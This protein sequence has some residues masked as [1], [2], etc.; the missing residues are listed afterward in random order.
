[1]TSWTLFA[2]TRWRTNV[3]RP[4][5]ETGQGIGNWRGPGGK[6]GERCHL[7]GAGSPPGSSRRARRLARQE[8]KVWEAES[9]LSRREARNTRSCQPRARPASGRRPAGPLPWPRTAPWPR[10]RTRNHPGMGNKG[11][12]DRGGWR[13]PQRPPRPSPHRIHRRRRRAGR[14]SDSSNR[15]RRDS[16]R[17]GR[18]PDN[19]AGWPS[20]MPPRRRGRPVVG[21]RDALSGISETGNESRPIVSAASVRCFAV[22]WHRRARASFRNLEDRKNRTSRQPG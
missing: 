6:G 8:I 19:R 14:M 4:R 18:R 2:P 7:S 1:M 22:Y 15:R 11:T 21:K 20:G 17:G 9:A 10:Y 16:S 13:C 5:G 12:P 3:R